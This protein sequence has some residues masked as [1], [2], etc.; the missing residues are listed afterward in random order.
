MGRVR[1]CLRSNAV[2]GAEPPSLLL[3]RALPELSGV[4]ESS[5]EALL[6]NSQQLVSQLQGQLRD[7]Q[8]GLDALLESRVPVT[9]TGYFGAGP[10]P[11]PMLTPTPVLAPTS[12][13]IALF[14]LLL[15]YILI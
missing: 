1:T 6:Q 7:I 8:G 5:C 12:V 14:F 13:P 4:L 2:A 9:F 11:A 10:T 3:Q 15:L